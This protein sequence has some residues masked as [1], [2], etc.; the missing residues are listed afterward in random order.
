M[1]QPSI[2]PQTPEQFEA[3]YDLQLDSYKTDYFT[4]I[5]QLVF[6]VVTRVY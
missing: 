2:S 6:S 1:A 5:C 3:V 4:S